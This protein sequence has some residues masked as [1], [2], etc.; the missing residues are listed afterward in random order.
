MMRVLIPWEEAGDE[1]MAR[2]KAYLLNRGF[3][4]SPTLNGPWEAHRGNLWRNVVTA[5]MKKIRLTVRIY[6]KGEFLVIKY[7]ICTFMQ[8]FSE[9]EAEF[10]ELEMAECASFAAKNEPLPAGLWEE[11]QDSRSINVRGCLFGLGWAIFVSVIIGLVIRFVAG[12]GLPTAPA[13]WPAPSQT[14][15]EQAQRSGVDVYLVPLEGFPEPLAND[16]ANWL[17]QDTGLNIK[18]TPAASCDYAVLTPLRSQY[19]AESFYDGMNRTAAR[20]PERSRQTAVIFLTEKDIYLESANLRFV[21]ATHRDPRMSLVATGRFA[22]TGV[23]R[24]ADLRLFNERTL[25]LLKR[26][27]GQQYYGYSRS[28]D[29]DSLMYSPLMG[30]PDLDAIRLDTW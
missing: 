26:A 28:S 30:V 8:Q 3:T 10:F 18:C 6:R 13:P 25:K 27:I 1:G 24:P 12:Y 14:A 16:L 9:A 22:P 20:L 5:D 19:I 23:S 29:P 7:F 15:T 21:F 4:V 2:A 11:H 17:R